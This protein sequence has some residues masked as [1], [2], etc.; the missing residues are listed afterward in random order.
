MYFFQFLT[1]DECTNMIVKAFITEALSDCSLELKILNP[2][3]L[4]FKC[5]FLLKNPA[6][7]VD[8]ATRFEGSPIC[9]DGLEQEPG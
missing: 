1:L 7:V 9:V 4:I 3:V 2:V 8:E 5:I 6:Y